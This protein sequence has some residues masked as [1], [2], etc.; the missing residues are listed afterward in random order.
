VTTAVYFRRMIIESGRDVL[1]VLW[2][3]QND[4]DPPSL[5]LVAMDEN[6]RLITVEPIVDAMLDGPEQHVEAIENALDGLSR[7]VVYFALGWSTTRVYDDAE[8]LHGLDARLRAREELAASTLLGQIVFER[9]SVY[10]SVPECEFTLYAEFS[11]LPRALAI[12]GPHG[13]GC[14]CAVCGPEKRYDDGGYGDGGYD[15]VGY[16]DVGYDDYGGDDDRGEPTYDPVWKRWFPDPPRAY[17]RWTVDEQ[18]TVVRCHEEGLS[19]FDISLLV[20]RQPSAIA[21]RLNKLGHSSKTVVTEIV[22]PAALYPEA[23]TPEEPPPAR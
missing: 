7:P 8:W 1:Q 11:A 2:G 5:W 19:C 10:I 14:A 17:K 18:S 12:P 6:L 23:V 13:W 22:V 9:S 4:V 21:S 15:D 3:A 16:D 20:Q